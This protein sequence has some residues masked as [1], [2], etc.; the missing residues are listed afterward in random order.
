MYSRQSYWGTHRKLVLAFDVGTTFSGISYCILDPGD[1]PVIRG[2]SKFPSQEHV[3]GSNKI[4]SVMYYDQEGRVRAVGAETE[5]LHIVEKAE[6]EEW[7]RLE[8]WKLHLYSEHLEASHFSSAD[9][10]PLPNGKLAI[11]VLGDFLR[12]LFQCAKAYVE[13]AHDSTIW[14]SLEDRIDLILTHPNGWKEPQR[15]WIR[16]AVELAGL[17]PVGEEGQSRVHLLTD[18]EANLH[19]CATN[20]LASEKFEAM[21][22]ACTDGPEEDDD[23]SASEHQGVILIDA[24]SETIDSSAYSM[25]LSPTSFREIAPAECRLQGSSFVTYRTHAFLRALLAN[26]KYGDEDTLKRMTVI[27]DK[28]TKMHF[29]SANEP[30]YIRF[31]TIRDKDL[32]YNIRSGQLRLSG[33]DVAKL[34][35]PSVEEII[36][37]F[38]VQRKAA[39]I[40]ITCVFLVGD[41]AASD[42]LHSSLLKYM[43]SLGIS[44]CRPSRHTS[45]AVADGAVSYYL[46][47]LVSGRAARF[48]YGVPCSRLYVPHDAEHVS[49]RS[50]A[51]TALNGDLRL[52]NAFGSVLTKGTEVSGQ[53][54]F[55]TSFCRER[56]NLS[57]CESV[58]VD[59]VAYRG[60]VECPLWVDKEKES[61]TK[62]CTIFADTSKVALSL[63]P[64]QRPDGL[65]VYYTIEFDVVI[66]F[67]LME[68]KAQISW[69]ENGV[70]VRGPV[71][72]VYDN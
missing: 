22:I 57:A 19:F 52:P 2:V 67:D 34:F 11:E 56:A 30:Q 45:K 17:V 55:R 1:V 46:D 63:Q 8:W 48:T 42:W 65:G 14:N 7:V 59:I 61:Y 26:S 51:F 66:L 20:I 33:Q 3:G 43:S 50:T 36:A 10:P 40:P 60:T 64:C 39:S 29:R 49:R 24:G 16:K 32:E 5:Q 28:T 9:L 6:E 44:F 13:E 71:T 23:G 21:L 31:G 15:Q 72:V 47:R 37:A 18:G 25:K 69:K 38:E 41:F 53:Q 70:E 58:Q 62:L 4:P 68:L 54:E 27:F 35:E 12:Y